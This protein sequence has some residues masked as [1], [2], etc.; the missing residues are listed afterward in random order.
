METHLSQELAMSRVTLMAY[1]NSALPGRKSAIVSMWLF[2]WHSLLLS[3]CC[4][5]LLSAFLSALGFAVQE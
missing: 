1:C 3:K 2:K 5:V 4:F